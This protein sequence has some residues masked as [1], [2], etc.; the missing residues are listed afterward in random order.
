MLHDP[1]R[2]VNLILPK[3]FRVLTDLL[4][5]VGL[6]RIKLILTLQLLRIRMWI[7][8]DGPNAFFFCFLCE[9][10]P[11]KPLTSH[12][13]PQSVVWQ[14]QE[15]GPRSGFPFITSLD[16]AIDTLAMAPFSPVT[17][18]SA[19][20]DLS[21]SHPDC[22]SDHVRASLSETAK[23]QGPSDSR[24]RQLAWAQSKSVKCQANL[25]RCRR[26]RP[27]CK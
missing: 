23:I 20:S 8:T 15:S 1:Y 26:L 12:F 2:L 27:R 9:R 22:L 21:S 14:G 24:I 10:T 4:S 19:E 11:L 16:E 6:G 7:L 5:S 17:F 3:L 25:S 18:N 13:P